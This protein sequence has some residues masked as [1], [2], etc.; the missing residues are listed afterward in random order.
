MLD[1][2]GQYVRLEGIERVDF[3]IAD[4]APQKQSFTA[5][6]CIKRSHTFPADYNSDNYAELRIDLKGLEE[7]LQ[8]DSLRAIKDYDVRD[9]ER[10]LVSYT[11]HAFQFAIDDS[12]V[13]IESSTSGG[14]F[15]GLF[16]KY[17]RRSICFEQSFTITYRPNLPS[18]LAHLQYVFAKIEELLSLFLGSYYR[19]KRP[20]FV[21]HEEP[22]EQ[23]DTVFTYGDAAATG[24]LNP[25]FFLV[26]FAEVRDQFG[27]LLQSWLGKS[28]AFGAG[29]YLYTSSLR[30][31]QTYAED[32]LFA[33]CS[34]MEAL[35]RNALDGVSSKSNEADRDR[36]ER[37]LGLIPADHPDKKWLARKLAYAHEPPLEQRILESLRELPL[38][39]GKSELERF[40]TRCASRRNDISH[41]GGPPTGMDYEP[42]HNEVKLLGDALGYLFHLVILHRIGLSEEAVLRAA[43][44]SWHAERLIKKSFEAVGL[45]V[46]NE[47]PVPGAPL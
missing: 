32:R 46:V 30:N 35:H 29:F 11:N 18:S 5:V 16:G 15:F 12:T 4:D 42:F 40:A 21:R 41:R 14:S 9:G 8:L 24:E 20:H 23:W 34:G 13:S 26:P 3:R 45:H 39:F 44:K 47:P 37:L 27:P 31:Q 22:F 38:R 43:T 17:P 19:L 36:A 1:T 6:T 2:A 10:E 25:F 7:W 33:L 28:E